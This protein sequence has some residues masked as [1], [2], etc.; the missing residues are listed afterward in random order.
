M[1]KQLDSGLP[2]DAGF[3][4]ETLALR[5]GSLR[6]DFGEHSEAIFLTSSFVF[7]SAQ[8]AA[9]AFARD[10]S[11][12]YT[13]FSNPSLT[14]LQTRLAALEGAAAGMVTASGMAAILAATV[15]QLK[16][17]DHLLAAQGLFGASIQLFDV[18]LRRFGIETT[19]VAAT[20]SD[21]WRAAMRPN[22][23]MLFAET[24]SNPCMDLVDIAALATLAHANDAVLVVDNSFCTALVQRPLDLGAD[25]VVYSATKALDGQGRVVGGA[26][27]GGEAAVFEVYKFM[28]AAGFTLSPFNAWVLLKGLET[29][30][31]RMQAQST[32]ALALAQWLEQQAAVER[33]IYPG[34]PSHP[35]HAL[36]QRQQ[37][38]GG[39]LVSFVVKGGREAAWRI[40]DALQMLSITGNLGDVRTT[41]T[42]PAS[43]THGRLDPA[44]RSQMGIVE[45]LLRIS[46]GLEAVADIQTDLA[47]GLA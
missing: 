26:V 28:R 11:N 25:M 14:M 10:D 9:D 32:S 40:L 17:G 8:A 18:W 41:I 29:L 27:L 39:A 33:V 19:F 38:D 13:R 7:D 5:A 34:L 6:S 35:Q 37:K 12:V 45:G 4:N 42:H 46:V 43:T 20:D 36:A 16:A 23:R 1:S 44:L 21:A 15:T 3:A 22:T 2:A 30:P 31:L 47:R 24:P